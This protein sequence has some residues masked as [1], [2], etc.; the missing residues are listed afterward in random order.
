[1]EVVSLPNGGIILIEQRL[2]LL[3]SDGLITQEILHLAQQAEDFVNALRKIRNWDVRCPYG[4]QSTGVIEHKGPFVLLPWKDKIPA[5][6]IFATRNRQKSFFGGQRGFK[7]EG[8]IQTVGRSPESHNTM[9]TNFDLKDQYLMVEHLDKIWALSLS[10]EMSYNKFI[11]EPLQPPDYVDVVR[12]LK[13]WQFQKTAN[14]SNLPNSQDET[15]GL[16]VKRMLELIWKMNLRLIE[17]LGYATNGDI[18]VDP[19]DEL[20]LEFVVLLTLSDAQESKKLYSQSPE[21]KNKTYVQRCGLKDLPLY[22]LH[23]S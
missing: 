8:R 1:M 22:L 9:V 11:S 6:S 15:F 19:Q 17:S 5:S 7:P 23:K 14:L 12:T 13:I 20:K 10:L 2:Y 16:N 18:F 3:S 4:K 21:P